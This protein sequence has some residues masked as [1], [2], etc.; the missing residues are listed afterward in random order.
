[1]SWGLLGFELCRYC[2]TITRS[3]VFESFLGYLP[4][5]VRILLLRILDVVCRFLGGFGG[6]CGEYWVGLGCSCCVRCGEYQINDV[7]S[8]PLSL[9]AMC[10][11]F[12]FSSLYAC[13]AP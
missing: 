4:S 3:F 7:R 12:V 11:Y 6:I 1:M 9:K 5:K 13:T 10:A 8:R 2:C